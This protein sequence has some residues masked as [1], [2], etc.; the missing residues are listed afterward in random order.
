MASMNSG[1]VSLAISVCFREVSSFGC[2][3]LGGSIIKHTVLSI[4]RQKTGLMD[5]RVFGNAFSGG[6]ATCHSVGVEKCT[7]EANYARDE[8]EKQLITY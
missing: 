7:R 5:Q 2:I 4:V 1:L 8:S 3:A 6:I